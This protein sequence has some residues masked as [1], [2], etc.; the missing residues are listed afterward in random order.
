MPQFVGLRSTGLLLRFVQVC[1]H[2]EV[3]RFCAFN[4]AGQWVFDDL[5]LECLEVMNKPAVP[6]GV[7]H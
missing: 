7:R 2:G 5:M 6:D 4:L 3:D 1:R